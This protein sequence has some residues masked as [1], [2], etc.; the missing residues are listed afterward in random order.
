MCDLI[1]QD[2]TAQTIL[3]ENDVSR[4]LAAYKVIFVVDPPG[5]ALRSSFAEDPAA[6]PEQN[7]KSVS[8]EPAKPDKPV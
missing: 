1:V 7:P 5:T 6:Q 4:F 3:T 2:P 8:A